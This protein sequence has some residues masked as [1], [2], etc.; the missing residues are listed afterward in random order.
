MS[1]SRSIS[2]CRS[3]VSKRRAVRGL[4]PPG[5]S[6][7]LGRRDFSE[8]PNGNVAWADFDSKGTAGFRVQGYAAHRTS[9]PSAPDP[10]EFAYLLGGAELMMVRSTSALPP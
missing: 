1:G 3:P 5:E 10:T 6:N 4:P 2:T 8:D 7:A 9:D